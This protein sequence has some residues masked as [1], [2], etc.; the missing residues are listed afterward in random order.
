MKTSE[1]DQQEPGAFALALQAGQNSL[2]APVEVT[3]ST[4]GEADPSK[5][6][7]ADD[8]TSQSSKAYTEL[9]V[10]LHRQ[11]LDMINLS[12]IEK[13]PLDEFRVHRGGSSL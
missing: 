12:V 6:F 3:Y 2:S 4:S 13:M 10:R 1:V 11:L 7:S 9:K 5:S 8:H